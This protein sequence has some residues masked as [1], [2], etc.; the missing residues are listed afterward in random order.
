MN[1]D[2]HGGLKQIYVSALFQQRRRGHF[3]RLGQLFDDRDGRVPGRALDVADIGAVDAGAI[4]KF[5][6][7]PAL[8]VAEPLEVG[9]EALANIHAESKTPLSIINLQTISDN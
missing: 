7:N 3:Q 4:S 8:L 2:P 5:L 6:L 9:S 1:A